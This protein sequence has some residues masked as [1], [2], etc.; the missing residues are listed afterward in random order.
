MFCVHRPHAAPISL[1]MGVR[2]QGE[3]RMKAQPG[4]HCSLVPIFHRESEAKRVRGEP[5]VLCRLARKRPIDIRFVLQMKFCRICISRHHLPGALPAEAMNS[6]RPRWK[7]WSQG[8]SLIG[9]DQFCQT[10]AVRIWH[11]RIRS[12]LADQFF[13]NSLVRCRAQDVVPFPGEA[14]NCRADFRTQCYPAFAVL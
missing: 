4:G 9:D 14:C 13:G 8:K 11:Q 3:K 6:V 2:G 10:D 7:V 1:Q 5:Q 12:H